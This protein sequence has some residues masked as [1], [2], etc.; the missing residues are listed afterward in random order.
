[1]IG[2]EDC[3]YGGFCCTVAELENMGSG[4]P[5]FMGH[6]HAGDIDPFSDMQVQLGK[7]EKPGSGRQGV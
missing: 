5:K 2:R 4:V 3:I 7:P 6:L 1:M